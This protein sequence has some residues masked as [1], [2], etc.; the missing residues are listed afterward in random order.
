[1]IKLNNSPSFEYTL[2][3]NILPVNQVLLYSKRRFNIEK[4]ISDILVSERYVLNLEKTSTISLDSVQVN[5]TNGIVSFAVY[6]HT[7]IIKDV[8]GKYF[9]SDFARRLI[10]LQIEELIKHEYI[11]NINAIPVPPEE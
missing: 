7:F 8:H 2:S 4:R 6:P 10:S 11:I 5:C 1:M 9:S 3:K